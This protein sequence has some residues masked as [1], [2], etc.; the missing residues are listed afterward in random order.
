[1]RRVAGGGVRASLL[2][3]RFRR[4]QRAAHLARVL[5]VAYTRF[6]KLHVPAGGLELQGVRVA[7]VPLGA[8]AAA[9]GEDAHVDAEM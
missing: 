5:L 4:D 6:W 9:A 7:R 3:A 1:M 2:S 8:L